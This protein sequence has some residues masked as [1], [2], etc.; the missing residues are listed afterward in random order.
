MNKE[1]S[2]QGALRKLSSNVGV[3]G[4]AVLETWKSMI[5]GRSERKDEEYQK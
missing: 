1:R 5:V 2:D 4:D 3:G